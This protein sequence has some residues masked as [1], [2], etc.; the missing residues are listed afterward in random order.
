[1]PTFNNIRNRILSAFR[2]AT[3]EQRA[4]LQKQAQQH[5]AFNASVN[6]RQVIRRK[7]FAMGFK[8]TTQE[9]ALPRKQRRRIARSSM[10]RAW[11][12]QFG[13]EGKS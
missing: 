6:T 7:L 4:A 13:A 1:M 2:R 3:P 12:L 8:R 11:A 9:Y 10:H 5:T